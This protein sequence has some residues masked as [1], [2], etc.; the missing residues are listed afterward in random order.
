MT[1][2]TKITKDYLEEYV[3][4]LGEMETEHRKGSTFYA[5]CSYTFKQAD[6]DTLKAEGVDASD[7]L[8]VCV[9]LNGIYDDW[10]GCEWDSMDFYKVE[11]YEEH[12]PEKVIPAHTVTRTRTTAFKPVWE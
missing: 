11:E 5:S 7:F 3:S 1:E 10:N 6:I 9:S 8:N 12:V 2:L 4:E